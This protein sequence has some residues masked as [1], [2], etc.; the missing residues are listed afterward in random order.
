MLLGWGWC[1]LTRNS[2]YFRLV[3]AITDTPPFPAHTL[4]MKRDK[5]AL[6][7]LGPYGDATLSILTFCFVLL[8]LFWLVHLAWGAAFRTLIGR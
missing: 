1:A 5:I 7:K 2:N 6:S 4:V 8:G 3:I